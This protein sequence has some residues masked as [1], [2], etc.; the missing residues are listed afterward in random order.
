[1]VSP[2]PGLFQLAKEACGW[3]NEKTLYN[4]S[5]GSLPE[6]AEWRHEFQETLP[7]LVLGRS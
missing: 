6:S 4:P 3:S 5:I 7:D 2:E 1:M